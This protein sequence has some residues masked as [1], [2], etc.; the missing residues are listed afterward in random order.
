MLCCDYIGFNVLCIILISCTIDSR[1]PESSMHV[2]LPSIIFVRLVCTETS[3]PGCWWYDSTAWIL[4]Y[5]ILPLLGSCRSGSAAWAHCH[6]SSSA[7]RG[8]ESSRPCQGATWPHLPCESNE[9]INEKSCPIIQICNLPF[10]SSGLRTLLLQHNEGELD[11]T[12]G[13]QC[14]D[15]W[16]WRTFESSKTGY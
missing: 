14:T 16:V 11:L 6:V 15:W 7:A 13:E 12:P 3:K 1:D 5:R 4:G 10:N 9:Q 2:C 8:E